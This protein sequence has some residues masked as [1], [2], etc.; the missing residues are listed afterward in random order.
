MKAHLI[1]SLFS[2]LS[3]ASCSS[4]PLM[5]NQDEDSVILTGLEQERLALTREMRD[6][7]ISL[8]QSIEY[9]NRVLS[10]VKNAQTAIDLTPEEMAQLEWNASEVPE[11]MGVPMSLD[12]VGHPEPIIELIAQLT[13]YIYRPIGSPSPL[14]PPVRV[15]GHSTAHQFLR[16]VGVQLGNGVVISVKPNVRTIEVNWGA[17]RQGAA[18]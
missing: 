7:M 14:V 15:E 1:F 10:E 12:Q 6:E 9:S 16:S 11:G 4:F 8:V 13:G 18:K 17:G 5:Q 3:L 2:V